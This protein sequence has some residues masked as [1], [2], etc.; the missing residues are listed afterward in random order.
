[1]DSNPQQPA[2][3]QRVLFSGPFIGLFFFCTLFAYA[4]LTFGAAEYMGVKDSGVTRELVAHFHDQIL[5]RQLE[6]AALACLMGLALGLLSSLQW[7]LV[8]R[9]RPAL[10]PWVR[11]VLHLVTIAALHTF[12]L[13]RS[14]V[15]R[16]QLYT[17]MLYDRGGI[18]A[19]LQGLATD[20]L[21][22]I[23]FDIAQIGYLCVLGTLATIAFWTSRSSWA[24]WR[25]R[26]LAIGTT[27]VVIAGG[28]GLLVAA[29]HEEG[30]A[31]SLASA[32]QPNV[33]FI[34]IDSLRSDRIDGGGPRSGIAPTL[35]RLARSGTHFTRTYTVLPRTF[36]S[37]VSILTGTM[38]HTH[39]IRH[40]FPSPAEL[41]RPRPSLASFLAQKG[42][43]TAVVTDY[44]GDIFSRISLGFQDRVVPTFNL[45]A[46]IRLGTI[47]L[48]TNLLPY[49]VD[50]FGRNVFPALRGSEKLSDPAWLTDDAIH[51]LRHRDNSRPFFLTLFYSVAHF[52][53]A[54]PYP[55]YRSYTNARYH[56]PF[57]Y[58]KSK[59]GI[60]PS[61]DDIVQVKRLYDGCVWA[62]DHELARLFRFLEK[63]RLF[64]NTI[65]VVF[66]DHGENL[67]EKNHGITHGE[68][69][70]GEQSLRVPLILHYPKAPGQGT[71]VG[72]LA[73]TIDIAPTVLE[74]LGFKPPEPLDGTS[75]V[76]MMRG[77][78]LPLT[79]LIETGVRFPATEAT[80]LDRLGI[81]YSSRFEAFIYDV[82]TTDLWLRRS[83]EPEVLL[84]KHR[85]LLDGNY[86]LLYIPHRSGV[87]WR[88][89]DLGRDPDEMHD[90][91][92]TAPR[93]L[94]RMKR[95][96]SRLVLRDPRV[97]QLGEFFVPRR[98]HK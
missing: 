21:P 12:F 55:Y 96:L 89:F 66:S 27:L 32:N 25:Y 29:V 31:P 59:F 3:W 98:D 46:M 10:R 26:R 41:K 28:T 69:L 95:K 84:A 72:Q 42:Y 80:E 92:T 58:H 48:H 78:T 24:T 47:K 83:F 54:A 61:A 50:L 97:L 75:L 30:P 90:I 62:V 36:P 34:A 63:S 40:M 87:I 8:L 37:F 33:L 17:E 93:V 2:L 60:K 51:W 43:Q 53:F 76:P 18:F 94:S 16:P 35:D 44:A 45:D 15:H 20:H 22:L 52:P 57:K 5:R 23:A 14:V 65:I 81:R 4:L 91:S 70:F 71:R 13:L 1:M 85:A 68:H 19:R 79:A 56:G 82:R 7:R 49:V 6:M 74:L 67:Y 11:G 88:L 39:G 73:R 9:S 64:R 38:P 77:E 86:K